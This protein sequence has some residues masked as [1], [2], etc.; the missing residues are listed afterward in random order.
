MGAEIT[1]GAS[2]SVA[3]GLVTAVFLMG[4]LK[5]QYTMNINFL[6]WL[7]LPLVSFGL[8]LGVNST[9]NYITCKKVNI[10]QISYSSIFVLLSVL[11][12]IG[13]SGIGFLQSP[14]L[15]ATPQYLHQNYGYLLVLAFYMFWAGMFGEGIASGFAQ[16]C[17]Q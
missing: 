12:F 4:W 13:I 17:G 3:I 1:F 7:V 8:A 11:L 16:G 10:S 9:I 5:D 2:I 15:S 14:I 6:K